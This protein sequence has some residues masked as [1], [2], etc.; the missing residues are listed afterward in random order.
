[1]SDFSSVRVATKKLYAFVSHIL[2]L[3]FE[4]SHSFD[5]LKLQLQWHFLCTLIRYFNVCYLHEYRD[6]AR[7]CALQRTID[8]RIHLLRESSV[9]RL[10]N[11]VKS[12]SPRDAVRGINFE[13]WLQRHSNLLKCSNRSQY[14]G[15]LRFLFIECMLSAWKMPGDKNSRSSNCEAADR[16]KSLPKSCPLFPSKAGPVDAIGTV[17]DR[18]FH[19]T[20]AALGRAIVCGG[21]P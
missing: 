6:S 13:H 16:A 7:H 4:L 21:L 11:I 5:E 20:S 15:Y 18:L 8:L 1:M 2:S 12:I 3:R 10:G 19:L 14:A 17:I 9:Y